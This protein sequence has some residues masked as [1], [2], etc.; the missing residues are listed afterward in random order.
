ME[1]N[2]DKIRFVDQNKIDILDLINKDSLV[3]NNG[4]GLGAGIML[5][6]L[7]H[8]IYIIQLGT[9]GILLMVTL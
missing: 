6:E 1:I 7:K 9:F 2:I 5:L 3:I 4:N 8:F